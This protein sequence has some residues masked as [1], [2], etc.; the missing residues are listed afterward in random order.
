MLFHWRK[1]LQG[2]ESLQGRVY[3]EVLRQGRSQGRNSC[4]CHKER[5]LLPFQE[6]LSL[7]SVISTKPERLL[8]LFLFRGLIP[9]FPERPVSVYPDGMNPD[10]PARAPHF[11]VWDAHVHCYPQAVIDDPSGWARKMGEPHWERLVTTGPQGWADPEAFLRIMDRD[12]IERVLLQGWYWE[13]PETAL[14]QN[15][16]HAG[17]LSRYPDRFMACA[18]FHPAFGDPHAELEKA[19]EWGAVAVGECLAQVQSADGWNHAGWSQLIDWTSGTGWPLCIHVTEPVGHDYP[20]RVET[21]L[22]EL[23]ALFEK[24]PRQK[25]ICAHFGGGLPFYAMNSR[26]RKAL[27]NVWYDSAAGPL[28]YDQRIWRTVVDLVGSEKILFGS[29]FPLLL[30]PGKSSDPDWGLLM[31]E[32]TSSGLSMD[33]MQA[34]AGGNLS[35]LLGISS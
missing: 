19:R 23:L 4:C 6:G 34:V 35:K 33:E 17:W 24:Y 13:N 2:K 20:G 1:L 27:G 16:W 21:P 30:Y 5:R 8:R 22:P 11:P 26:V 25:W 15:D 9:G 29:D 7:A 28:L 32:F 31:D 10:S 12:R 14:R 18:A 3:Q